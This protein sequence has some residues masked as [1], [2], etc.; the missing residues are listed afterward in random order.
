MA[1]GVTATRLLDPPTPPTEPNPDIEQKLGTVVADAATAI[2][3]AVGEF[4][5]SGELTRKIKMMGAEHVAKLATIAL[6]HELGDEDFFNK[7]RVAGKAILRQ[8]LNGS[9]APAQRDAGLDFYLDNLFDIV[10]RVVRDERTFRV[11]MAN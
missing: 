1:N 5:Q 6:E 8:R 9:V 3:L 7:A 2:A 10:G 4:T 11:A